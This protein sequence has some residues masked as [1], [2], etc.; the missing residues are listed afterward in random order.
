M[1]K[2]YVFLADG[3]EEIEGLTVVD[4]LRRAGIETEMVS[5]TGKKH[6]TGSHGIEIGA[7]VLFE[8]IDSAQ[9][10]VYVL[11]G[12]GMPGT[13][14]LAAH[15]G[16][17]KLLLGAETAGVKVAAICAAPSVLGELGL[18]KGHRAVCYPGFEEKLLGAEVTRG[19]VEVS[20]NVTTSRGMGTAIP[21][22][23]ALVA[24]LKDQKTADELGKAIIYTA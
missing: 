4:I 18:L 3:F 24:Q 12:G 14:H 15:E 5:I 20:G 16:L 8:E 9:A 1:S 10:S 21:F 6:V 23:L 13:R 22:A 11:P 17:S 7:D 19:P 2:V